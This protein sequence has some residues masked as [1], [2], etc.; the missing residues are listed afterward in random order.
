MAVEQFVPGRGIAGAAA[1]NEF[2]FRLWAHRAA[3]YRGLRAT[4]MPRL[5]KDAGGGGGRTGRLPAPCWWKMKCFSNG[6][7]KAGRF[8]YIQ[9]DEASINFG[10]SMYCD[11]FHGGSGPDAVGGGRV[12]Q[13]LY[14]DPEGGK[15]ASQGEGGAG[16][17]ELYERRNRPEEAAGRLP[18]LAAAGRQI[19]AR[20]SPVQGG[21]DPAGVQAWRHQPL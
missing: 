12:F 8:A 15:P 2:G 6:L 14:A 1:A 21:G 4:A 9:R 18:H 16:L 20:L 17:L 3:I 10:C 19:P 5:M 11:F 7:P 13:R